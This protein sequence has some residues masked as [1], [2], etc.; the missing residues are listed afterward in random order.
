MRYHKYNA[1][2]IYNLI[3]NLLLPHFPNNFAHQ[4]IKKEFHKN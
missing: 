1:F 2:I 3:K 4:N